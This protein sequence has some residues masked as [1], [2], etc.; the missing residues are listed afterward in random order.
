[1]RAGARPRAALLGSI[2]LAAAGC[3]GAESTS[4][5]SAAATTGSAQAPSSTAS[6]RPT[7]GAWPSTTTSISG[8]LTPTSGT[9][10][11]TGNP[12]PSAKGSPKKACGPEPKGRID[13]KAAQAIVFP[14]PG[15]HHEWPNGTVILRACA[16]SGLPVTYDVEQE[17]VGGERRCKL[18]RQGG[19]WRIVGIRPVASCSVVAKQGGDDRYAE[20]A[21]VRRGFR[22]GRQV[23]RVNWEKTP[24][25]GT[26]GSTVTAVVN[27]SSAAAFTGYF[28]LSAT[29]SCN[30]PPPLSVSGSKSY[31]V[32][33]AVQLHQ[34]VGSCTLAVGFLSD[35]ID[36]GGVARVQIDVK[37]PPPSP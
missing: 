29:G 23:V 8:R 32:P 12:K 6:A 37:N 15:T 30:E 11:A 31:E 25:S 10:A 13:G 34:E 2:L 17:L 36:T 22:M 18:A 1:M 27:L 20:A 5:S 21:P 33:F 24:K 7:T 35:S 9:P 3:G 26:P 28:Q 19:Q 4:A 16:T 14:P